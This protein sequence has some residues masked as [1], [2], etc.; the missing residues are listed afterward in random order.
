MNRFEIIDLMIKKASEI[1]TAQKEVKYKEDNDIL[2]AKFDVLMETVSI[3]QDSIEK[4]QWY[5]L[6]TP[7]K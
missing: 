7:K 1:N 6:N 2:Q 5:G 3:V 4:E